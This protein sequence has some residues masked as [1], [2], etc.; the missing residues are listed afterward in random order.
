M[1]LEAVTLYPPTG[2]D[3][4]IMQRPTADGGIS[5]DLSQ[6]GETSV[7]ATWSPDKKSSRIP[8]L[9][10]SGPKLKSLFVGIPF[11]LDFT[12]GE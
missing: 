2:G 7:S 4:T 11:R 10:L 5:V 12:D 9:E 8:R 1:K 3:R 6:F